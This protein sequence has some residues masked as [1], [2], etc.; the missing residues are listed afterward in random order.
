MPAAREA[1]DWARGGGLHG[2]GDSLYT[3]FSG[4]DGDDI[5]YDAYR[6]LVRHCAADLRHAMLWLG[7]GVGEW[8]S[9]TMDERKKLV[10]TAIAEV[11]EL[12]TDTV[13][14]V[15]TQA[16]SPKDALELTLHA[17]RAGADICYLQTPPME[18]H[19][20]EGT[21]RFFQYIA[22]RT[23]IALG[24]FNSPSSG[25]A[26]T[27]EEIARVAEE[28][29]AVC[30]IKEGVCEPWRSKA[31]HTLAPELVVWEC[32]LI[33]YRAGWLQAGIVGPAQLGTTGYLFETPDDRRYTEFWTL[34][35]EGKLADAIR[36]ARESLL[37]QLSD[38]LGS[39]FVSYPGRPDYFT[40]WGEAFRYAASVM[41][42]PMGDH[43][44]SRP[45]QAI[46]PE[47]AKAQIRQAYERAGLAA[48]EPATA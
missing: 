48:V 37:D 43:P 6:R 30:A 21:L 47:E 10:E 34:I 36:H 31:I 23:D 26:L 41:G 29:P 16:T 44:H 38:E 11:R 22:D 18:L 12:G 3:P 7:S 2:I 4:P 14:Q 20:G 35:W 25:Y 1:R 9:L 27:P 45:P 33:V 17:Q 5:D 32:D 28:I 39:W 46:L 8:W 15:C 24:M 40:H 42:L 13:V 19:G